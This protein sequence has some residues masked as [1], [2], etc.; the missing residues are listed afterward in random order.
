M[1]IYQKLS[2][3]AGGGIISTAQ[4]AAQSGT[5]NILIGLGGTGISCL[6]SIKRA[7]YERLQPDDLKVDPPEYKHIKFWAIDSDTNDLGKPEEVDSIP[8]TEFF[9]ISSN[10]IESAIRNEL[11]IETVSDPSDR[12][13]VLI[14]GKDH[15][16]ILAN[17]L[18][19]DELISVFRRFHIAVGGK[20][21]DKLTAFLLNLQAGSDFHGNVL[22]VGIVN[23]VLEWDNKRV[24]LRVSGEAVISIIDRDEADA[25]L[26]KYL[27]KITATVNVVSGET[28]EVFTDDAVNSAF[29]DRV[30][31]LSEP[32]AIERHAA[33]T[34]VDKWL[35]DQLK[36]I[37]PCNVV[38]ANCPLAC[39]TVALN[40]VAILA[41]Q[42][43]I[44]RRPINFLR[45]KNNLR[46]LFGV[47]HQI[48]KT[49]ACFLA[50]WEKTDISPQRLAA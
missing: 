1:A 46:F 41:G 2:L 43:A 38:L 12:K 14:H 48:R 42:A 37:V 27:L 6:R 33:I 3:S 25:E 13:A 10:D 16:H 15:L 45:H 44:D 7:V 21:A 32:R 4:Q 23:Q 22:A 28:A 19:H 50:I 5:A 29:L 9:K 26:R 11:V 35:A 31:H 8:E 40:L 24:R 49:K 34:I 18:V 39:D 30:L 20:C 47:I 36:I 17:F